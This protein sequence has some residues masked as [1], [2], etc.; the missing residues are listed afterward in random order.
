MTWLYRYQTPLLL[1]VG[2]TLG[3]WLVASLG[4]TVAQRVATLFFIHLIVVVALQLFSGN[5]GVISFAHVGF[6]GLGAYLSIL[7]TLP[8]RL[9]AVALPNLYAPLVP[10]SAPFALAVIIAALITA[11]LAAMIG[12][13]L[14]RLSGGAAVIATFALLVVIH[15]VLLNWNQL[16]N[17]PRTVF[18]VTRYTT[19]AVST[20]F[21]IAA[22]IIAYLFKQSRLG[23]LLRASREDEKAAKSLGVNVVWV[24][25]VA[26]VLSALMAAVAGGLYAHFLTAFGA[27]TFYLSETFLVLAMLIVGGSA[28]VSGAVAGTL[29]I[30][31]LAQG[32][33]SL[34]AAINLSGV[35]G[36][37]IVGTTGVVVSLLLL[38][39]LIWR[40]EGLIGHA[41]LQLWR[42]RERS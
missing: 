17:G 34:E 24:R 27:A 16:T 12:W 5:S 2:L 15:V 29:V 42:C 20:A 18:G 3:A 7:L 35:L 39:M 9:K 6:M 23:L 10:L 32:V 36:S 22:V 26:F 25:W 30:T 28:S 19:L 37:G 33:R 1:T 41:E 31:L 4:T 40:P 14:M 38:I 21:G 8:E 13:P 11:L